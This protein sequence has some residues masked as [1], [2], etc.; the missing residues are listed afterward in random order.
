MTTTYSKAGQIY[1]V[2][3]RAFKMMAFSWNWMSSSVAQKD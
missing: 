3:G 2:Y 1:L